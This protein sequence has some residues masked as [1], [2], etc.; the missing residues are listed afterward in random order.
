M[1]YGTAAFTAA[2]LQDIDHITTGSNIST[3][4]FALTN[5]VLGDMV[6]GNINSIGSTTGGSA[7]QM[8]PDFR[9]ESANVG[10]F[11]ILNTSQTTST[12]PAGIVS[13]T[14]LRFV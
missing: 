8:I 13:A 11:T 1:S 9:V 10:R 2:T 12:I 3:G 14:A 5:A 4:T 6:I 7:S